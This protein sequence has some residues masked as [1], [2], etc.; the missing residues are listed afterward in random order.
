M[1]VGAAQIDVSIGNK[2]ANLAK[3]LRYLESAHQKGIKLIVFPECALTGYVF[4]SFDE[5]FEMSEAVPGESTKV[6]EDA[7]RKYDMIMAIGLLEKNGGE[8]YNTAVL[9]TPDGL[10][11][12]YRKTHTL[13]L[14]VDRFIRPGKELSTFLLQDIM[15]G[16]TICYD[17]RFPEAARVMGLKGAQLIISPSNLPE[18]AEVYANFVNRTRASENRLFIISCNRVGKER[19]VR[20]IG[21]SQIIDYSGEIL[22]EGS[23]TLEEIIKAEIIIEKADVKHVVNIPGE[24]EFDIFGDRRPELYGQITVNDIH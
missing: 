24:Y 6:L 11:G 23:E 3:C 18:G 5:A 2:A 21:Y 9:I 22:A 19:N 13:V 17:Q 16:I 10:C 4:N 1:L 8:L 20:F 15:V 7:C 14:G 12:K